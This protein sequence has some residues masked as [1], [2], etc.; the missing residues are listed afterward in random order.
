MDER[1]RAALLV[2]R[3]AIIRDLRV[4]D[5]IPYILADGTINDED[6]QII[7]HEV[8]ELFGI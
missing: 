1:S 4:D 6:V 5:V 8:N 2:N 3:P 7:K